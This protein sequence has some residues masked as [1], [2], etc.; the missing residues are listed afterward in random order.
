MT[1][2]IR[3]PMDEKIPVDGLER[4]ASLPTKRDAL[5]STEEVTAKE[6]SPLPV[7]PL[8][9]LPIKPVGFFELFRYSTKWEL[10]FDGIGLV[11]AAASGAAQVNLSCAIKPFSA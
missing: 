5:A 11:C 9:G 7:D 10:F 6:T 8:T 4:V 1:E 3:L 2:P